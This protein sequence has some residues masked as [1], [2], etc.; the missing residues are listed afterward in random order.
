MKNDHTSY[1]DLGFST[2]VP[3]GQH[4][5]KAAGLAFFKKNS[6]EPN[7]SILCMWNDWFSNEFENRIWSLFEVVENSTGS[8]LFTRQGSRYMGEWVGECQI[9]KWHGPVRGDYMRER[10]GE[11]QIFKW[12]CPVRGK[13]NSS[14]LSNDR[15]S[16]P[17]TR[18]FVEYSAPWF[19][20]I[21]FFGP[22]ISARERWTNHPKKIKNPL[23][24][25]S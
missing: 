19:K 7:S 18:I 2:M 15:A 16:V 8:G 20:R 11:S 21:F 9:F 10:V 12:H 4:N 14:R 5:P 13:R 23:C 6:F 24:N 3:V 1:Y 25:A 22:R 17:F